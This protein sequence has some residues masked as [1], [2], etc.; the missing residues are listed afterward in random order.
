MNENL[1]KT[2]KV[3]HSTNQVLQGEVFS[4]HFNLTSLDWELNIHTRQ[5]K[6]TLARSILNITATQ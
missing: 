3:S 4:P 5:R 6:C 1:N 2:R